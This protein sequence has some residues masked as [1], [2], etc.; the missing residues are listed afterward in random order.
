MHIAITGATGFVGT[1]LS[2]FL[3]A[4]GHHVVLLG[5]QELADD[6]LLQQQLQGIDGVINL[7][8]APIIARWSD[9]YKKILRSS[10]ID[11]T[12]KLLD[13]FSLLPK[14]PE[15]FISTSA[16]GVYDNAATYSEHDTPNASDFLGKL[17]QEWEN[18]AL[19]AQEIGIKTVVFR[20]GIVLGR[21]GG[22]MNKIA[23]P[24]SLGLGGTIGDGS[25]KF[26][27]I[28]LDDLIGAMMFA[29]NTPSAHG[30]YN[31]T[32]PN[33]TTNYE[34]TK[35]YGAIIHRPTILPVPLFVLNLLFGE[36]STVLSDGQSVLP[37]RLL[38][39]GFSFTYPSLELALK[40]ILSQ[41]N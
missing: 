29:I 22:M 11:V 37:A 12:K 31:L 27:W 5:R 25:Q 35:T 34:F 26:S 14:K 4:Q 38:Q 23:L 7:A 30:V 2:Q 9:S 8:G 1:H 28:H 39:E 18:E 13:A 19:K 21:G 24:F 16:V 10:R 6:V 40:E 32:A 17:A 36:G 3:L 41:P 20:F 33:P 15:F